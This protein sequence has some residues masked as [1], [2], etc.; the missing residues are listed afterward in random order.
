MA[1]QFTH[2]LRVR[3]NECDPQGIVFNGNYL[4]YFDV[5]FNEMWHEAIGPWSEIIAR[6]VDTVLAATSLNFRGSARFEDDLEVRARVDHL[7]TTS[8]ITGVTIVRGEEVIVAGTLRHVLVST[9]D[10][11][12][13]ELP[14]WIRDGLERFRA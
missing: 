13:T 2:T 11:R 6:G 12:K 10:W 9:S 7:G 4:V 3:W 5:V 14:S 8:V 1:E